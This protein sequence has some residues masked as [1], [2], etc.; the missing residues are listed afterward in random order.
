L[1]DNFADRTVISDSSVTVS[2]TNVSATKEAGEPNHAD[3]TGGTSVWWTWTAPASGSITISTAG[4]NFD[5]TL[6][7]YTGASVSDLTVV[8]S[9][10]DAAG[11]QTSLVT[12]D[13]VAGVT[14][15]IAVDGYNA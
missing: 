14:Y 3:N 7:V 8:A 10:D 9:N 12:F 11:V 6:G 2:G 13:A 1:N 15:Q 4:S 5:T